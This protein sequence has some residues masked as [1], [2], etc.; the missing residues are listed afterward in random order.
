MLST[1]R[2]LNSEQ[3]RE[4][5]V[6]ACTASGG[7]LTA[8]IDLLGK[9]TKYY[10]TDMVGLYASQASLLPPGPR[11]TLQQALGVNS[12]ARACRCQF[13][14]CR[15]ASMSTDEPA[16]P[17]WTHLSVWIGPE[18]H[19]WHGYRGSPAAMLYGKTDWREL[20]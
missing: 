6:L 3:E 14:S 1:K 5:N 11:G 18:R 8:N 7:R 4:C 2:R 17:C 20:R 19:A 15:S 9:M 13:A 10:I 12:R 16:S